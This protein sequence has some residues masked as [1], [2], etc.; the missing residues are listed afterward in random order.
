MSTTRRAGSFYNLQQLCAAKGIVCEYKNSRVIE[1]TTPRGDTT[2]ECETVREAFDTLRHDDTFAK[3]PIQQRFLP[4]PKFTAKAML[5][6]RAILK[7][8]AAGN[9]KATMTDLDL[10][11]EMLTQFA[12]LTKE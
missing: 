5:E 4:R 9:S 1:M 10:A 12:D 3:L 2:A 6:V 8:D 11:C 7:N